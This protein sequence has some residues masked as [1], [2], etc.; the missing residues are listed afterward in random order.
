[1]LSWNLLRSMRNCWFQVQ[2]YAHAF[3]TAKDEV[4]LQIQDPLF[5]LTQGNQ[6]LQWKPQR[7]QLCSAI[8]P[9]RFMSICTGPK[10]FMA[11]LFECLAERSLI[12]FCEYVQKMLITCT[13]Y[14]ATKDSFN[15]QGRAKRRQLTSSSALQ[16]KIQKDSMLMI[17]STNTSS[18]KCKTLNADTSI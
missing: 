14:T 15:W 4:S 10:C 6:A 18:Q 17:R 1:M 5:Q 12:M 16:S 3:R 11:D 13:G 2:R 9:Q 7:T 8:V